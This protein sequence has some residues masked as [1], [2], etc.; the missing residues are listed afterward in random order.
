M[1]G[2]IYYNSQ[3]YNNVS[4]Q[5]FVKEIN[6]KNNSIYLVLRGSDTKLGAYAKQYNNSNLPASHIG[7]I[8]SNNGKQ[9][10]YH[11]NTNKNEKGSHLITESIEEFTVSDEE[12]YL[13]LSFWEIKDLNKK[14]ILMAQNKIKELD[15]SIIRF[16]Y[17]FD[18][19]NNKNM[20]CSEFV[21]K[22]LITVDSSRFSLPQTRKKVL[23][24]HKF[25]L[26]KDTLEYY[27][28]DFFHA[29]NDIELIG[30]WKHESINHKNSDLLTLK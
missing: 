19:R 30:E 23:K 11:V 4:L 12:N 29:I 10:V 17:K 27:P 8:V 1:G 28:V 16:D 14:H 25:F 22:T 18:F 3:P 15:S 24:S 21:Y 2:W 13:Y 6:L 26:K 5:H 7:L 9:H 20:Y